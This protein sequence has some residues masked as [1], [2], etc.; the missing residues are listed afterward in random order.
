MA[1]FKIPQISTGDLLRD[2]RARKTQ[3]GLAASELID[4]GILVS[5]DLVNQMVATRLA[6]PDCVSGYILDGFPRTLPQAAWLDQYLVDTKAPYPVVVI[7]L[8]VDH[9]E[10]LKR[11]TGRRLCAQGRIYNIYSQPP[12]VEG[13]CDVCGT[14]LQQRKDD[15]V[16][17]FE[18][19]MKI[20][21]EETAPVI[22]HYQAQGRFAQVNGFQDVATVTAE[23]RSSLHALRQSARTGGK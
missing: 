19:R 10:L 20:F 1:E 3:L 12:M 5:D 14:P 17:V 22:P 2:H 4:K 21:E 7:S 8:V 15:T 16:E 9:D 23:I 18:Q 13:I 11:I 6:D